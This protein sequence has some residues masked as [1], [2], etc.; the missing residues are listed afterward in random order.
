MVSLP[1]TTYSAE[2]PEQLLD[3]VAWADA[4]PPEITVLMTHNRTP[5]PTGFYVTGDWDW[6]AEEDD[7]SQWVT[8]AC[9]EIKAWTWL[10]RSLDELAERYRGDACPAAQAAVLADVLQNLADDLRGVEFDILEDAEALAD[11]DPDG[12]LALGPG[13]ECPPA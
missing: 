9:S 13:E 7:P 6:F 8:W 12:P 11:L 1:A 5:L 3:R 2:L 4:T 10:V